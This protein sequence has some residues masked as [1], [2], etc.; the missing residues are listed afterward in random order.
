MSKNG[1]SPAEKKIA[2]RAF[3]K[4][5]Q[6]KFAQVMAGLKAKAA[7]AAAPADIWAIEDYL[8][9]KRREIDAM[10]DY[11]YSQL[12][13]VFAILIRQG[14]LDERDLDGLSEAKLAV[15]R[16]DAAWFEK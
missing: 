12:L 1:W 11:R 2:R 13:L 15:I 8:R 14:L 7:A 10:F 3:D 6:V 9:D 16:K 5:L 4:A